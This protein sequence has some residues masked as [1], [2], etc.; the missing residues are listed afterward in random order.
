MTGPKQVTEKQLAVSRR[1]AQLSTG[2]RT[3]E[4]KAVSRWNALTHGILAQAVS[5]PPLDEYESRQEFDDLLDR[6]IDEFAPAS[7]IEELLVE[8]VAIAYWRL[9]RVLRAEGAA[10]TKTQDM[11]AANSAKDTR[12]GL[13]DAFTRAY[14]M[15]SNQEQALSAALSD[16]P[17]LRRLMVEAEPHLRDA[18][19]VLILAAAR[20]RLEELERR[21]TEHQQREAVRLHM[22]R[23]IPPNDECEQFA[24]YEIT[25]ERQVYRA[26]N[27]LERLQRMR[28]GEPVPPPLQ[29]NVDIDTGGEST[30][31]AGDT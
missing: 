25:F 16:M 13:W 10:I 3:P 1:N 26:L 29:I 24:R 17:A 5:P 7:A 2:P 8:R 30:D 4:G 9:A 22:R 31:P 11:V 12:F 19:D 14:P 27:A 20:S 6:L 28:A 23:S 15:L 21:H 18:E